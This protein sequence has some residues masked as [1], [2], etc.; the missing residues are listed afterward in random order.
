MNKLRI[1]IQTQK[2]KNQKKYLWYM[3]EQKMPRVKKVVSYKTMKNGRV[4]SDRELVKA[5]AKKK[6]DGVLAWIYTT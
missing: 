1:N 4:T 2:K 3:I 6:A 5:A